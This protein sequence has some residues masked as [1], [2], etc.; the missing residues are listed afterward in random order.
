MDQP[1]PPLAP[2]QT[3]H[4]FVPR[5]ERHD[6]DIIVT[7]EGPTVQPFSTRVKNISSSGMLLANSGQLHVGD[8]ISVT[9]PD[10]AP[11]LCVVARV[12]KGGGAGIKFENTALIDGFWG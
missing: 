11:M 7:I 3:A 9:L 10:R 12:K 8:V 6:V 5:A 2:L 4:D 1:M